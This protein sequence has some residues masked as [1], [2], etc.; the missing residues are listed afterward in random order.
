LRG[1]PIGDAESPEADKANVVP[2]CKSFGNRVEHAIDGAGA[3]RF[4]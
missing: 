1:A 2:C 3:I 4:R